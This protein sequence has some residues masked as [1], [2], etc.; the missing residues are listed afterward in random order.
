MSYAQ[1]TNRDSLR[2]IENCLTALSSKLYHCGISYAVPRN[3]LAKANEK[4]DWR[5]YS[6]FAQVLLKKVRPLYATDYFRLE[7]D[8][9]VYAFDSST[10]SL[11]LKLCPWAK[12]RK[13]KGGIKMHTL[14]DL[15]GNLPVSVYLTEAAVHDVKALDNLYIENEAIYLMDKGYIDFYR[16]FNLIHK[17]NAFFVTRA[18]ENMLFETVSTVTVDQTTGVIADER[19]KLTGVRTSSWYPEELRMITYE[20]YSTNNVYRFLTNNFEYEPLMISELYRERWSVELFFKWIKQHLHIKSFYG[21][22]EN[23]IYTQIWIAVCT[24]LLLAYAKKKMHINQ[25]LHIISKNVGLFLTDKNP[26]NE[27]FNKT[28]PSEEQPK[29]SFGSLFEP[30]DF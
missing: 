12:F 6:D 3:T 7:L 18:K 24:Y 30:D 20:D 29:D 10:I 8:N 11:C 17:K 22:L 16:L 23:A 25:S 26:L 5:I 28:V 4:R 14:L 9:M 21:T 2:D 19:I 13:E 15:R 1:L 27:L